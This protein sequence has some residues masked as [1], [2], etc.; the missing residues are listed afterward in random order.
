MQDLY[1]APHAKKLI[2]CSEDGIVRIWD[3]NVKRQEVLT[4]ILL[5]IMQYL[6]LNDHKMTH[7]LYFTLDFREGNDLLRCLKN[8][9]HE[10]RLITNLE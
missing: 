3:M 1:Y 6:T 10:I 9:K 2:S 7:T 8:Y 4:L 5:I